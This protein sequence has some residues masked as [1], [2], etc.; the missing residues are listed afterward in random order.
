[1]K[2]VDEKLNYFKVVEQQLLGH[3]DVL[4]KLIYDAI[5]GKL[6]DFEI[7][8]GVFVSNDNSAVV[9]QQ[10]KQEIIDVINGDEYQNRFKEWL[11]SY[12]QITSYNIKTQKQRNKL[13][14]SAAEFKDIK[15]QSVKKVVEDMVGIGIESKF[16][17]PIT[18]AL[19]RNVIMGASVND[20]KNY[21]EAYIFGDDEVD[22]KLTRYAGQIARDSVSQYD[23]QINQRI[24]Q[25]YE[26]D[27]FEYVGSLV[28]DSRP[29]CSHVIDSMNG[30]I[31]IEE[32]PML[33]KQFEGKGGMIEGT[34]AETFAIYR[35]GYNCRHGAIPVFKDDAE[36]Q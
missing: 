19:M 9:V 13:S 30:F 34:T 12:D 2:I 17:S 7:S 11:K 14:L 23:G 26:M 5:N 18:E 32:L 15:K 8:S 21:L 36:K 1:M 20:T 22:G 10:L 25:E 33:L 16:V 3:V 35:G 27:G 28:E 29:F 24:M 4:N 6:L 31:P